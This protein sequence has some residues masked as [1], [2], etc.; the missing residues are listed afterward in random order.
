VLRDAGVSQEI[1][2]HGLSCWMR[3]SGL[4]LHKVSVWGLT[5]AR[6]QRRERTTNTGVRQRLAVHSESERTLHGEYRTP[7]S[8]VLG[9]AG[10]PAIAGSCR[11]QIQPNLA[12]A[13]LMLFD[14]GVNDFADA[15]DPLSIFGFEKLRFKFV[16]E[17]VFKV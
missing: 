5:G 11:G 10:L 16:R 7:A 3:L 14:K 1:N 15:N 12:I 2:L 9:P 4:G 6:R 17:I 8:G 13:E